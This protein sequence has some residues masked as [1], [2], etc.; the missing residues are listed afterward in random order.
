[1]AEFR[2]VLRGSKLKKNPVSETL[3][4]HMNWLIIH[5]KPL[6]VG[7]HGSVHHLNRAGAGIVIGIEDGRVPP[8]RSISYFHY[9]SGSSWQLG[10]N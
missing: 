2:R 9:H 5:L 1:M 7:R 10:M 6:P 8:C 3:K 4:C